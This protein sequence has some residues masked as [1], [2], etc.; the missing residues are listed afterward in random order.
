MIIP[1]L[2]LRK[3][4]LK[5]LAC[6]QEP[7][8]LVLECV[9]Y[10]LGAGAEPISLLT[11]REWALSQAWPLLPGDATEGPDVL[12]QAA[13]TLHQA[14]GATRTPGPLLPRSRNYGDHPGVRGSEAVSPAQPSPAHPTPPHPQR[15]HDLTL[16][17][18][19]SLPLPTN[20]H[21]PSPPKDTPTRAPP[22]HSHW[23]V[24]VHPRL[25]NHLRKPQARRPRC[26]LSH[27]DTKH[28]HPRHRHLL[29][30]AVTAL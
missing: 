7:A 20:R 23:P 21:T 12:R 17:S 11:P 25:Y 8:A 22:T 27:V 15:P 28:T 1:T 18:S 3:L 14:R 5:S 2:E 6:G 24:K 9:P 30:G 4:W 19:P 16:V 13:L 26:T 10:G 29:G